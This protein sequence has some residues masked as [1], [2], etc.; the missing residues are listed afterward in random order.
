MTCLH[1]Y[2]STDD[3]EKEIM[4]TKN[5]K[6]GEPRKTFA[7]LLALTVLLLLV[8]RCD[9]SSFA[10][11][12]EPKT[13]TSL[14]EAC[15]AL[16][17][18][19]QSND[20]RV[21]ESILGAGRELSSSSDE[22]EN[23][24]ERD[25]F[26]QK[27]Q[28]MHRLVREPDGSTVLYVGAENWPFP[29]PLVSADDG[30]HFDSKTG[31]QEILFRAIGENEITALLTA[32]KQGKTAATGYD[33]ISQYLQ[34]LLAT[35]SK[36][37]D[38]KIHASQE[39]PSNPFHGYY[40]R[41]VRGNSAAATDSHVSGAKNTLGFALVAYPAEYRS[42]GVMSFIVTQDGVVHEKDLGPN[43]ETL[44]RKLEKHSHLDSAWPVAESQ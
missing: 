32:E 22:V 9:R 11:E 21:L 1:Y 18:A 42:S 16:F 30:W 20:E 40:F 8:I 44:A 29:I 5:R 4:H 36:D 12:S 14:G 39:N 6:L 35:G 3:L 37:A 26:S 10:Q 2:R 28:E 27:Y 24:L 17:Y 19:V 38:N 33:P 7:R 25:R 43:T 34:E 41:I 15:N 13:F 23:K 31:V